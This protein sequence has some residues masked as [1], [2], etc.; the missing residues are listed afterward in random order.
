MSVIYS[1]LMKLFTENYAC[2]QILRSVARSLGRK[3]VSQNMCVRVRASRPVTNADDSIGGGRS[4]RN[5]RIYSTKKVRA[6]ANRRSGLP[7]IK[8]V[9]W[10]RATPY[11]SAGINTTTVGFSNSDPLNIECARS[12]GERRIFG[13][14]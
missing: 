12:G 13:A 14:I 10:D 8:G 11:Q 2:G 1:G 7:E 9:E 6:R 4:P 5:R 3:Y